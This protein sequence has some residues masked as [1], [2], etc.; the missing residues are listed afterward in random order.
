MLTSCI[1]GGSK[2]GKTGWIIQFHYEEAVIEA[3]KAAIPHTE[4]EWRA[5][6]TTW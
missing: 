1:K 3:L 6:N 5:E 4:R 2:S